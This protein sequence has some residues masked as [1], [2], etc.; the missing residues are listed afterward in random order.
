M[1]DELTTEFLNGVFIS[2]K[3]S[4][5]LNHKCSSDSYRLW[6]E[7]NLIIAADYENNTFS[8]LKNRWGNQGDHINL[9]IS[10]LPTFL[11]NPELTDYFSLLEK[12][13]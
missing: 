10:L 6:M 7:M 13:I 5:F 9:P 12:K 1:N 2:D 8:V 4:P 11:F 3:N